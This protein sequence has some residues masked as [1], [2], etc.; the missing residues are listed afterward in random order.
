MNSKTLSN[1]ARSLGLN[2][3][4][5]VQGWTVCKRGNL[6]SGTHF[7]TLKEVGAYLEHV[8]DVRTMPGRH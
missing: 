7:K 3:V 4:D 1:K 6:L 8:A 2:L 5:T